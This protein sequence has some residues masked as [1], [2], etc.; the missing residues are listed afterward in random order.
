[1]PY[2]WTNKP[3]AETLTA[4]PHRSLPRRGFVGFIAI[5]FIFLLMPLIPL[6]GT[7]VLWALLP[8]LMGALALLWWLFERNY[9][10]GELR[11]ELTLWRDRI[12]LIRH[13]PN[14]SDQHWEANPY[15]V[16]LELHDGDGPVDQYITLTGNDR[17]VEL[18]AFL[19]PEERKTLHNDL[20]DRLRALRL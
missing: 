1:M 6:L 18:G 4:W 14:S 2:H 17:T 10:D 12:E 20:A 8:F 11:E 13:N 5:T 19:S 9:R 16:Q 3:D 7:P 15:W